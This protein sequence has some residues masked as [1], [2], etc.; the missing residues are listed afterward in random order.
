MWDS[1]IWFVIGCIILGIIIIIY[2]IVHVIMYIRRNP[3]STTSVGQHAMQSTVSIVNLGTRGDMGNQIFQL[4]CAIAASSRSNCKLVLPI[5]SQK[6]PLNELFDLTSFQF[7]DVVPDAIYYEYSNYEVINIPQDG[8]IYDIRGYR[9]SYKYFEDYSLQIRNIFRPKSSILNQV[10]A[11]IPSH[12][13]AV[14]IRKGDYIKAM[15]AIPLLR[16]FKQCQL[17]YYQKGIALLRSN[18]PDIPLLVCTDSPNWVKSI[19]HKLDPQA[20]LAPLIS[21]LNPKF[22]DFCI[23]YNATALVIS[24]STYGFWAAYLN[25]NRIA[26]APSPWWNPEGFVGCSMGLDSPHLHHPNFYILDTDTGNITREPHSL[27]G[28]RPET[29]SD[30]LTLFKLIRGLIV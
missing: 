13:I 28:E 14:H 8:R 24:N 20:S 23:L 4:A 22:S 26:I 10:I 6:L 29:D 7:H 12:Y 19:L 21:G 15:H 30:T 9:Q 11:Q 18:Y 3:V 25:P 2:F 5:T 27:I 1:Y 16:E 17:A